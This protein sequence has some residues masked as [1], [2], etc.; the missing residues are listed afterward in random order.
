M[1]KKD[2]NYLYKFKIIVTKEA[3]IWKDTYGFPFDLT[4]Q[5][6]K[7]KSVVITEEEFKLLVNKGIE[8]IKVR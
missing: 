5:M 6:C 4:K 7:E 3:F 1:L 8:R 2:K